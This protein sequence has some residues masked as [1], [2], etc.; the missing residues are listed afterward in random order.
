MVVNFALINITSI[1]MKHFKPDKQLDV[2]SYACIINGII[3][4]IIRCFTPLYALNESLTKTNFSF[5]IMTSQTFLMT[6]NV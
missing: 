3:L 6:C 5:C 4:S 2:H 1:I